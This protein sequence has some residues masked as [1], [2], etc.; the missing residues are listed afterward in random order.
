MSFLS[1]KPQAQQPVGLGGTSG[2]LFSGATT[3]P[4]AMSSASN[5]TPPAGAPGGVALSLHQQQY[6]ES[7]SARVQGIERLLMGETPAMVNFVYSYDPTH[8]AAQKNAQ[9]EAQIQ[10]TALQ[11]PTD[12]AVLLSKWR[13]ACARISER[14]SCVVLPIRGMQQLTERVSTASQAT[15]ILA[16]TLATV[17]ET[18]QKLVGRNQQMRGKVMSCL[19]R[20]SGACRDRGHQR[21]RF[22]LGEDRL[23]LGS[24]LPLIW[25]GGGTL[26][27]KLG[28]FLVQKKQ[29]SSGTRGTMRRYGLLS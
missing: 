4:S 12:G 7:M 25:R 1:L 27:E 19:D 9:M 26:S 16:K 20:L 3:F 24:R 6:L 8:T 29:T 23:S 2:G 5:S 18:T 10:A 17:V 11:N 22:E 21:P 14:Q 13:R 15:E 28:S